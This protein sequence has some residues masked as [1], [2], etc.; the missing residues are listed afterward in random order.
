MQPFVPVPRAMR[1]WGAIGALIAAI[2]AVWMF[3]FPSLVPSHFAWVAEPRL[4]QAF[5]GAGYVFRTAF[6]LQFVLARNWL[7]IRWTF[8]GNLAFTGTL[9]LATLWHADEMNWRFL[10][11][12]LWVIFYTYEPVTM[13]FTAP[14]GED[15]RRLHLTSGGPILPWF[16][17]F[18]I[19]AVGLFFLIGAMLIINPNWLNLR[20]PWDL[21]EFDAR[22][23][24]AW[25][26]GWAVWGG[27]IAMAKDWD[28]VRLAGAL[29]ILFGASVCATLIAFRNEFDFTRPTTAGYAGFALLLTVAMAFFYW[30]Q[31]R[32]RPGTP[33]KQDDMVTDP[34]ARTENSDAATA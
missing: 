2:F 23:S 34:A 17:R 26:L 15:V 14:M 33:R 32:H 29:G 20:W 27:T 31:E 18:L 21:N 10:V 11:A 25:L 9:L 7:N 22:I 3:F 24:A 6:F 1:G 4:A 30:R 28:E 13:I 12:H 16:R 19:F 8:W 5:I